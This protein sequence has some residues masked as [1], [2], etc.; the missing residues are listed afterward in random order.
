M[1]L[2]G[3][4][5]LMPLLT[6]IWS[7]DL[8]WP[9]GKN[10][11][12]SV[13]HMD[14]WDTPKGSGFWKELW[15]SC[16]EGKWW[17][18]TE[19]SPHLSHQTA[20]EPPSLQGTHKNPGPDCLE[21]EVYIFHSSSYSSNTGSNRSSSQSPGRILQTEP[22]SGQI[23]ALIVLICVEEKWSLTAT[24]LIFNRSFYLC[25]PAWKDKVGINI[26]FSKLLCHI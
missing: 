4:A 10:K 25:P 15:L 26:F 20:T 23:C 12:R 13:Y 6:P 3:D 7:L 11:I 19:L 18:R 21:A 22:A 8:Q 14:I 24:D 16:R 9:T 17:H 1:P 5:Q 2:G